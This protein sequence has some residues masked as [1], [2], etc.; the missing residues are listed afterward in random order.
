METGFRGPNSLLSLLRDLQISFV[1]WSWATGS[2]KGRR[3]RSSS[4]CQSPTI[5][6]TRLSSLNCLRCKGSAA[7]SLP[8]LQS[9]WC[10]VPSPRVIPDLPGLCQTTPSPAWP[11]CKCE[12]SP[13]ANTVVDGVEQRFGCGGQWCCTGACVLGTRPARSPSR[14][15]LLGRRLRLLAAM[16]SS[17]PESVLRGA[18]FWWETHQMAEPSGCCSPSPSECCK[19]VIDMST[20][21]TL[22]RDFHNW[23]RPTSPRSLPSTSHIHDPDTRK[24]KRKGSWRRNLESAGTG[25]N[26]YGRA[27][28][29]GRPLAMEDRKRIV[30]LHL[31][32][33]K[34]L[35]SFLPSVF[36]PSMWFFSHITTPSPPSS[37][38]LTLCISTFSQR[39]GRKCAWHKFFSLKEKREKCMWNICERTV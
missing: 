28:S 35:P 22:E 30:E 21:A 38:V 20:P 3:S 32:G 36:F 5:P 10:P 34:V 37:R 15:L 7:P 13:R 29:P 6:R 23:L 12:S 14:L 17:S 18:A 26:L 4:R 16:F 2:Q 19:C 9:S 25:T 39:F 11:S 31:A 33:V 1:G 27:Y 8:R 24:P